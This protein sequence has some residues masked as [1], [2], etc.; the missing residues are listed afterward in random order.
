[1]RMR[2]DQLTAAAGH[3][4]AARGAV[5]LFLVMW[6]ANA[7]ARDLD[8]PPMAPAETPGLL[9]A[10]P[11]LP[12]TPTGEAYRKRVRLEAIRAGLPADVADAVTEVES[13][14]RADTIGAD[15]EVGL[16]QVLPS[17]ARMLGF[18]GTPAELAAPE[19]NIHLGVTYLAQAWQLAG[20][21]ICTATMKYR[22]GHGET[23]FSYRSVDYCLKV[24]AKLLARGYPVRG[25][26]P[27]ATFGDPVA[28][29]GL[30]RGPR[31]FA[32]RSPDL[33]RVNLRLRAIA[34]AVYAA[35][36]SVRR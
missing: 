23:R 19:I 29:A 28:G 24:R 36:T 26:V 16:M 14:Y 3:R 33:T 20:G 17:T 32:A 10:M 22:A 12:L 31:L 35:T 25:T 13:G 6:A 8:E 11:R 9:S 15:G 27:V 2:I 34:D 7:A 21:D 18:T 5:S 30:R 1:M 4:I